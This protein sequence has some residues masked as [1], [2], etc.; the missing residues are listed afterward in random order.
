MAP[1]YQLKHLALAIG[2]R[3]GSCS[4]GQAA[5]LS[6]HQSG[7][8]R[9]EDGFAPGSADEL[10]AQLVGW[11]RL[12]QVTGRARSNGVEQIAFGLTHG[13]DHDRGN[14]GAGSH[15]GQSPTTRHVEI[16]ND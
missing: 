3:I 7:E 1:C 5:E 12:Q 10:S 6:E 15:D 4:F 13:Q 9:T 8:R 16:A 2:E 11:R 14:G